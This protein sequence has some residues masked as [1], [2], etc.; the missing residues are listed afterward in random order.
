[1][2]LMSLAG[3]SSGF[4]VPMAVGFIIRDDVSLLRKF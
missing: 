3:M 2:G 4:L 1:M